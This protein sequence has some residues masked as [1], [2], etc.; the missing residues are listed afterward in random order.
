M[1]IEVKKDEWR[2][3]VFVFFGFLIFMK[4]KDV[5]EDIFKW[6]GKQFDFFMSSFFQ[7]GSF[8]FFLDVMKNEIV[9]EVLFFVFV[10]LQLDDKKFLEE[11]SGLVSV[12]DSFIVEE[13][14]KDK[15]DKMVEVLVL[16]VVILFKDIYI[17]IVDECVLE[18]VLEEEKGVIN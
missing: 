8:I 4:E 17:L 6:E 7:G 11:I 12:K 18:K 10:L 1:S 15:F 16:E 14:Y 9:V 3:V 2:L 13:F 5:F